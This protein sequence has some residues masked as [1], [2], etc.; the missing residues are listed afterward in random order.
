MQRSLLFVRGK[1]QL[2]GFR[3]M[4]QAMQ[5]EA[6][7]VEEALQGVAAQGLHRS[8]RLLQQGV[9]EGLA[10]G[11]EGWAVLP[12]DVLRGLLQRLPD[13]L[14]LQP[15]GLQGDAAV[16]GGPMPAPKHAALYQDA[17]F[18]LA[19]RLHMQELLLQE[20]YDALLR[21]CVEFPDSL[22]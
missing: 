2:A 5:D 7:R 21:Y 10:E 14:A 1:G 22:R 11:V 6:R 9:R 12:V 18:L 8:G 17:A 16:A 19:Q 13:I 4:I 15:D 3:Q 20:R